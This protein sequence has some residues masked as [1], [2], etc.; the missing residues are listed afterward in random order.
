M[1]DHKKEV[2]NLI[3]NLFSEEK[4]IKGL[5]NKAVNEAQ[6]NEIMHLIE[7]NIPKERIIEVT[8]YPVEL[9]EEVLNKTE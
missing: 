5:I 4:R 1:L 8:G 2:A 3:E 7:L 6:T 9:V